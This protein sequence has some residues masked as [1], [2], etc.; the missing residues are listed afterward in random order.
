MRRTRILHVTEAYA[1]GV[2]T[3]LQSFVQSAPEV[4]HH[5]LATPRAGYDAGADPE[6]FASV[7]TLPRGFR[8]IRTI[9]ERVEELRPD[10]VHLHSS[11]A[12]LYGRLSGVPTSKIIYSPHGFA[13]E[14]T[15]RAAR[16]SWLVRLV[17]HALT[18]RTARFAGVN[19]SECAWFSTR[20]RRP[21]VLVPNTSYSRNE[22]PAI[23]RPR[24]DLFTIVLSGRLCEQKDPGFFARAVQMIGPDVRS[25]LQIIWIGGG[26]E[27]YRKLLERE[28]VEVTDWMPNGQAVQLMRSADLY[29][30]SAAWEGF[31]MSV[32]EAAALRM[33]MILRDI[34]AFAG[35]SL[36]VQALAKEPADQA[37]TITQ[38]V[39]GT[40]DMTP[41]REASRTIADVCSP[42]RQSAAL[43]N[44]YALPE[45]T[46]V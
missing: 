6:V 33:P 18:L 34:R 19:L 30:H 31:P 26:G 1:G 39:E 12:G 5:L 29:V 21:S 11:F 23:D 36:P 4:E 27:E 24:N 17:E 38:L 37:R 40:I 16:L 20:S 42:E 32:V 46:S 13:F 28:G 15:G 14:R 41:F 9:S 3:A 35:L 44:L 8:A 25:R 22:G 10:W 7:A 43:R 45:A 2:A